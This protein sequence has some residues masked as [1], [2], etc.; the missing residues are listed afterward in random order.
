MRLHTYHP[1]KTMA[2]PLGQ[3]QARRP[4]LDKLVSSAH[5]PRLPGQ[6]GFY[7]TRSF[8]D[9]SHTAIQTQYCAPVIPASTPTNR[10]TVV[11]RNTAFLESLSFE[12]P[13]AELRYKK[14]FF[15]RAHRVFTNKVLVELEEQ[16]QERLQRRERI[17]TQGKKELWFANAFNY[18]GGANKRGGAARLQAGEGGFESVEFDNNAY[19]DEFFESEASF[20]GLPVVLE[21]G[22]QQGDDE[23]VHL[24]DEYADDT[25]AER[26]QLLSRGVPAA[27]PPSPPGLQSKAGGGGGGGGGG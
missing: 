14:E 22:P 8:P 9:L 3:G 4:F 15:K 13:I 5:M 25:Q 24:P 6:F 16:R 26:A 1:P 7:S 10:M 21:G 20:G 12:R 11:F 17:W 18:E 19:G 2:H 27:N 23:A